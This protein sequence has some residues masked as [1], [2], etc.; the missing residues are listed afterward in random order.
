[1]T[2]KPTT[3]QGAV[4]AAQQS[5]QTQKPADTR[6]WDHAVKQTYFSNGGK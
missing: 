4:N 6:Q 2:D 5:Q 3:Y 1:M